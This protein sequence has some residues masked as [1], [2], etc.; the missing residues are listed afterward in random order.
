MTILGSTQIKSANTDYVL[1]AAPASEDVS[2][3][4]NIANVS[5]SEIKAEVMLLNSLS[6]RV[7]EVEVLAGGEFAS[8]PTLSFSGG[9][10]IAAVTKMSIVKMLIGTVGS[11]YQVG[12]VLTI[13]AGLGA[14]VAATLRVLAIDGSGGVTDFEIVD[15]GAYTSINAVSSIGATGGSGSGLVLNTYVFAISEVDV[16]LGGIN[17]TSIPTVTT[18]PAG[19]AILKA[20]LTVNTKDAQKIE[21]SIKIGA[22]A[23]YER[24]GMVLSDGEAIAVACDTYGAANVHAWGFI[25]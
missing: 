8:F 20:L 22:N 24:S 2:F 3:T 7:A 11:N 15:G 14:G 6:G 13:Q 5:S 23:V 16:T 18:T 1:F 17:Y 10:A 4:L 21:P 9:N 12:D 19:G 25:G